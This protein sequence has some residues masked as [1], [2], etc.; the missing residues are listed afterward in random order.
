MNSDKAREYFSAY[1]EGTLDAGLE[2]SLEQ[3][4]RADSALMGEFRS[5]RETLDELEFLKDQPVEIPF[6][7]HERIT[8]KLDRHVYE[9]KQTKAPIFGSWVRN[10]AFAGLAAAAVFGAIIGL[11]SRGPVE[12]SGVLPNTVPPPAVNQLQVNVIDGG[13]ALQYKPSTNQRLSVRSGTSGSELRQ[14]L[15]TPEGWANNLEN[16]QPETALFDVSIAGESPS[17]LIAVPGRSVMREGTG[18]GTLKEFAKALA[19]YY[20]EPVVLKTKKPDE[21]VSWNFAPGEA[22]DAATSVLDSQRFSVENR[23]SGVLWIQE[24]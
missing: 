13:V 7:L 2:Q 21:T 4:L 8:A 6:D 20:R 17:T 22:V 12:T 14:V 5:F 23:R 3:R 16:K 1:A 9:Q 18:Q 19:G 24:N 10:L 15:V 11:S